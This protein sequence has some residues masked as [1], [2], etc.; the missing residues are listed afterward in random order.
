MFSMRNSGM[1]VSPVV[2][3]VGFPHLAMAPQHTMGLGLPI[4]HPGMG[5]GMYG[6][7]MMG[8]PYQATIPGVSPFGIPYQDGGIVQSQA[9][10]DG[11]GAP[12]QPYPDPCNAPG[13]AFRD[14]ESQPFRDQ[15]RVESEAFEK[16]EFPQDEA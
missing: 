7:G 4:G 5:I 2:V 16:V 1:N 3:P 10:S 8:A 13:Q 12:S 9:Y 14:A 6:P 15:C 11:S